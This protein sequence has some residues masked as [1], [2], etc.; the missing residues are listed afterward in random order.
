MPRNMPRLILHPVIIPLMIIDQT[1]NFLKKVNDT[2]P[3]FNRAIFSA[4]DHRLN[5]NRHRSITE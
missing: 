3:E 2:K 1:E 5:C 4:N